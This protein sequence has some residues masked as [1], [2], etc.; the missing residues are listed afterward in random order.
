MVLSAMQ[1]ERWGKQLDNLPQQGTD[2]AR[3]QGRAAWSTGTDRE[4]WPKRWAM[5]TGSVCMPSESAHGCHAAG[6][7]SNRDWHDEYST[8]VLSALL[9]VS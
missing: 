1:F 7:Y 2:P 5:K 6:R 4:A 3:R 8:S 9:M